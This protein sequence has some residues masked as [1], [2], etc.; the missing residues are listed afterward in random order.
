MP[1]NHPN[2]QLFSHTCEFCAKEHASGKNLISTCVVCDRKICLKAGKG[3]FCK[4][5]FNRMTKI[6]KRKLT[7][8]EKSN[9]DNVR[10]AFGLTGLFSMFGLIALLVNNFN[11]VLIGIFI[12]LI[13]VAIITIKWIANN[14][15][16]SLFRQEY[17]YY[18]PVKITKKDL[19]LY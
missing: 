1:Q 8:L 19:L 9:R 6:A 16:K 12:S 14:R 17:K 15:L 18:F 3:H 10:L 2:K 11:S 13:A 7:K 4:T 5:H